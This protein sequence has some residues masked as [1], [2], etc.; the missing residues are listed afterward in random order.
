MSKI[1]YEIRGNSYYDSVTLMLVSKEVEKIDGVEK[2]IV[3]MGTELNKELAQNMGISNDQIENATPN[4]FFITALADDTVEIDM[5]S[6]AVDEY[7]NKKQSDADDD[8]TPPTI[9]SAMQHQPESNMVVISVAGQYAAEEARTALNNDMNVM[10]F[11]DNVSVEDER[12]LKELAVDKGLLMM[13]PDCGTAIINNVPLA[14]A[15]VI[16]KGNIGVVGASGTGLQEATV[17]IDKLGGGISQAIGTGGRDLSEDIG[18]LMML[19]GIE[20]LKQDANTE[21]ILLISKPPA[22]SIAEKILGSIKDCEK[23][24]VVDFIGGDG[25]LIEEYGAVASVSLED[26]A[27]KAVLLSKGEEPETFDSFSQSDQEID[28]IVKKEVEKFDS[29]QKYYRGFFTGG[30]LAS[31][32]INIVGTEIGQILSN[33]AENPKD[34]LEDNQKS[35]KNTVIDFGEDEFTVGRPHPMIDPSARLER[36][37]LEAEDGEMA[38]LM[39]DFVLGY[40]SN[41]DPIGETIPKLNEA[42]EIMK[43]AGKHLCVIASVCGTEN[44]PQDLLESQKKLEENDVI[45]MQ[46]NAQASRLAALIMK[47]LQ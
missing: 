3:G 2:A 47:E 35:V 7:L 27:R 13:G 1:L 23:P 26:A 46:T 30:T 43:K 24:V 9:R 45:V 16:R 19:Q 12:E 17:T 44:D 37:P 32:A 33:V 21:V 36:L 5:I 25:D 8:Y 38:V 20:A 29:E 42:Q 34:I 15:N 4:D 6:Q 18:G 14:F 28:K 22:R 10:I 41:D 39:L 40:G 11:S 31:E